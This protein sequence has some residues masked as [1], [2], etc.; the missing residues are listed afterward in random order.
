MVKA[1]TGNDTICARYL[2]QNSFEYK[3]QFK[4]FINTNHLPQVE[5]DSLFASGRV[6]LIPFERHFEANEQDT[7]LKAK[8]RQQDAM[9]GILN[10]CIEGLDKLM[11]AGELRSPQ[12]MVEAVE[13]YR[14]ESDTIKN[15]MQ[16][17]LIADTY[18]RVKTSILYKAYG[19]W[20]RTN[21]FNILNNRDFMKE[22]RRV[23][24]VKHTEIGNVLIGYKLNKWFS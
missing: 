13:E 7:S 18:E 8:F 3:P 6:K 16:D 10:W 17:I 24:T 19:E 4:M 11:Q 22:L 20:C 14:S 23:A 2:H 5:D 1:L 21:G 9:S 15:F 12:V